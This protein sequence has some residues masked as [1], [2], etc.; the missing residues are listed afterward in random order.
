MQQ[1]L[2]KET[3]FFPLPLRQWIN[4]D[5]N[6]FFAD[7]WREEQSSSGGPSHALENFFYEGFLLDAVF[8]GTLSRIRAAAAPHDS[9]PS[10]A[11]AEGWGYFGALHVI[12]FQDFFWDAFGIVPDYEYDR[13]SIQQRTV[14]LPGSV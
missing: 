7:A 10:C 1:F 9:C 5:V 2:R 11:P 12:Q 13:A 3:I 4:L 6:P 14:P 8:L